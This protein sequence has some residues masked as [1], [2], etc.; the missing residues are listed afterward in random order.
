[1][2]SLQNSAFYFLVFLLFIQCKEVTKKETTLASSKNE[3][4]YAK[5]LEISKY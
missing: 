2:K 3:I 4:Q 5:G 1:M